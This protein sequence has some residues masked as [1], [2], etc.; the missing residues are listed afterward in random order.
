LRSPAAPCAPPKLAPVGGPSPPRGSPAPRGWSRAPRRGGGRRAE[1]TGGRATRP[2]AGA[3]LGDLH[4]RGVAGARQQ[5]RR[6]LVI[7][8]GAPG[9]D[10]DAAAAAGEGV[11]EH[12]RDLRE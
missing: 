8:M 7:E 10:V 1:R 4:V 6:G 9:L 3:A 11:V 2:P 12:A 5:P